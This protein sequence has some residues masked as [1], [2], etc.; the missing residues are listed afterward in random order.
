MYQDGNTFLAKADK[1]RIMQVISNLFANAIK[2]TEKEKIVIAW[3]IKNGDGPK[4]RKKR[5][6]CI[7]QR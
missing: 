4:R 1:T 6:N 5:C 7:F 2:F 3:I